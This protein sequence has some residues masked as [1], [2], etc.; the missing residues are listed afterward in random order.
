[1]FVVGT[2]GNTDTFL[3]CLVLGGRLSGVAGLRLKIFQRS[4][5]AV[6]TLA[7]VHF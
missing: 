1:M 7:L 4:L 2:G 5:L 3:Q 6:R